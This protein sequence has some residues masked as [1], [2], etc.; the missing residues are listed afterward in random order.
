MGKSN[1]ILQYLAKKLDC[2]IEEIYVGDISRKDIEGYIFPYKVIVGNANFSNMKNDIDMKKLKYIYGNADFYHS[3]NKTLYNLEMIHGD[4]SFNAFHGR[5]PILSTVFGNCN[6]NSADCR[7]PNLVYVGGDFFMDSSPISEISN[8][9]EI[10]GDARFSSVGLK[11]LPNLQQIGGKAWFNCENLTTLPSLISCKNISAKW[12]LEKYI[13]NNF[14]KVENGY[15]RKRSSS[16][17]K[18]VKY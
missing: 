9:V 5:V 10:G 15:V 11:A 16:I 8:L 12:D 4:A 17:E 3:Y 2:K 18:C 13:E 6:F 7:I 14:E 1:T